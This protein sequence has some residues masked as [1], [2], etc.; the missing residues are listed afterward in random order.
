MSARSTQLSLASLCMG[1]AHHGFPPLARAPVTNHSPVAHPV[2]RPLLKAVSQSFSLLDYWVKHISV[3]PSFVIFCVSSWFPGCNFLVSLYIHSPDPSCNPSVLDV[4]A[5]VYR[6]LA[7]QVWSGFSPR[8]VIVVQVGRTCFPEPS[9]GSSEPLDPP[10]TCI[11]CT[12][13]L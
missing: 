9:R 11:Y 13:C 5:W 2:F 4:W 6:S 7:W 8:V 12:W 3:N 1:G 10:L